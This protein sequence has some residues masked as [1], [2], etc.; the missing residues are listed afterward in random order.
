MSQ[1]TQDYYEILGVPRSAG[2]DE[3]KRAYR[4][5]ARELH[6]DVNG[7]DAHAEERFKQ[8]T[9]AYETLSDPQKRQAY[10]MFGPD[11]VRGTADDPFSGFAASGLSDI[12][13]AFF[14]TAAGA[15]QQQRVRRGADLETALT[16][17]FGESVFGVE[18]EV[19]VRAPS[20]CETC[21]GS[22]AATGTTPDVCATCQG[23][24]EERKVRQSMLGQ[25]ITSGP[26]STCGGRGERVTVPCPTCR[27]EGRV[28]RDQTYIVDIPPGVDDGSTL[29]LQGRGGAAPPGGVAG[30]LYVHLRVR[31]HES[32]VR[33]GDALRTVLPIAVTQAALGA[34]ILLETLDGPLEVKISPGTQSGREL[35]FRGKGVPHANGRGRGDLIVFVL[36][37]TP[38]ELSDEDSALLRQ[39]ADQR[40]ENLDEPTPKLGRRIR[41]MFR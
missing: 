17:E 5:L 9:V 29:R 23:S 15:G 31:P 35:R 16:L 13:E 22:G 14:S 30:D 12:F 24:G 10:D 3:I 1:I 38:T 2:D 19:S 20:V 11:G 7:G 21:D 28:T 27:G 41:N 40:G 8:L 32:L 25:V 39:F 26:C 6:P 33:D 34:V 4:K 37:E 36:V 18:K